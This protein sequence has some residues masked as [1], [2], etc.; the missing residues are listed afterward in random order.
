MKVLQ[1]AVLA[2]ASIPTLAF[3][4]PAPPSD[5]SGPRTAILSFK[6]AWGKANQLEAYVKEGQEYIRANVPAC[7]DIWYFWNNGKKDRMVI[8]ERQVDIQME[9]SQSSTKRESRYTNQSALWD[10]AFSDEHTN[11]A[12]DLPGL[13]DIFSARIQADISIDLK[14]LIK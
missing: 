1:T 2:L 6:P 11:I 5:P 4:A 14:D 7:L 12:K 9:L 13:I 3:A 10:W 8:G